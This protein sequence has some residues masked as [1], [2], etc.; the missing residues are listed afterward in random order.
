M[1]N[2]HQLP[3]FISDPLFFGSGVEQ[4]P[5]FFT[6]LDTEHFAPE[7][8]YA[9]SGYIHL[10]TYC[11]QNW[12]IEV[13]TEETPSPVFGLKLVNEKIPSLHEIN[14]AK[15]FLALLAHNGFDTSFCKQAGC[16]NYSLK[17]RAF[18]FMHFSFP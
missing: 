9:E 8:C 5:A 10:C 18:C 1:C 3:Q 17:G 11:N 6:T 15:H 4:F 13:S 7:L 12:Y 2:C 14:A 16:S